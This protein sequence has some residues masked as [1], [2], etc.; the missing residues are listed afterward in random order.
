MDS[1]IFWFLL[2]PSIL[3][4]PKPVGD[5][6]DEVMRLRMEQ[7]AKLLE[8]ERI[9]LERE[10]EQLE[11]AQ[12]GASWGNLLWSVVQP[13]QVGAFAGLLVLLLAVWFMWRKR[14]PEAEISGEEEK[15]KE[16]EEEE[17]EPWAYDLRWLFEEHTQ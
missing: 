2:L 17:D 10:V 12:R 14:S 15:E 8:E 16:E 5:G 6:L 7:R 9:R 13:W 3:Q 1:W 11:L 4:Y